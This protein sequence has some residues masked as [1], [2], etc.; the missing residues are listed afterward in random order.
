MSP[1]CADLLC[2]ETL[3]TKHGYSLCN[4]EVALGFSRIWAPYLH[5]AWNDLKGLSPPEETLPPA[6][7]PS[8]CAG[9]VLN[10]YNNL[11]LK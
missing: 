5:G 8:A 4:W 7:P 1:A 11:V 10:R 6:R 3:S 2:G 9:L